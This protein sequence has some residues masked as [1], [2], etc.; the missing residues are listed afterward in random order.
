MKETLSR[1]RT[2]TRAARS[3][4]FSCWRKSPHESTLTARPP[5][6]RAPVECGL[7][8]CPPVKNPIDIAL[9]LCYYD[10]DNT[11][12]EADLHE[13]ASVH[14]G[15]AGRGRGGIRRRGRRMGCVLHY[16]QGRY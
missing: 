3:W 5:Q 11:H 10:S 15:R 7:F 4:R 13:E 16:L 8:L 12:K 1:F 14:E 6:G 9:A 2:K